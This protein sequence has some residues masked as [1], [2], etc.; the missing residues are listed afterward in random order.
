MFLELSQN[1]QENT[2]AIVS[3]LIKLQAWDQVFYYEFCEISKNTFFT[4]HLWWL[5]FKVDYPKYLG[6]AL[7]SILIF[8]MPIKM[9]I[10][11]VNKNIGLLRKFQQV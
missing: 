6:L 7:D 8:C 2:C 11:K 3:F 1:L 4:E 10:A 9:A 5:L